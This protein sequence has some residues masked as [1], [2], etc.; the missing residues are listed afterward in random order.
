MDHSA[1]MALAYAGI[2]AA[3]AVADH[4]VQSD[5]QAKHKGLPG[6]TGHWACTKHVV[7]YVLTQGLAI[8]ALLWVASGDNLLAHPGNLILGL[9]LSGITHYWADR[10]SPLKWLA[11]KL[12]KGNFYEFGKDG[13]GGAYALDQSWHHGWELIAAALIGLS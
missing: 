12:G 7:G 6:F 4:W 10:R 11:G 1:H 2:R 13:L 5:C 9:L 3:A 8:V